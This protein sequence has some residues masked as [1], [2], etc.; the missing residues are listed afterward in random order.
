M[1][2]RVWAHAFLPAGLFS[3]AKKKAFRIRSP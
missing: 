3:G 1:N 2:G